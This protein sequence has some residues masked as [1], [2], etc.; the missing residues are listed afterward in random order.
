MRPSRTLVALI[1]VTALLGLLVGVPRPAPAEAATTPFTDI[2]GSPFKAD[3]E[4]L[5]AEGITSGCTATLY[6][7]DGKVTRGQMAA[8]LARMFNP[9]ATTTDYFTDDETSIFE[10]AINRLRAAGIAS[11]CAA[12]KFCPEALVARDQMTSFLSRAIPLS[13]GVGRN[14]FN[15]D[16]GNLHEANIDRAAMAGIASGCATWQFCPAG[17]VTRGQM[18]AF[19]HRVTQPVAPPPYP[20]PAPTAKP[21]PTPTPAPLLDHGFRMDWAP[22]VEALCGGAVTVDDHQWRCPYA[23][24]ELI[25]F[26]YQRSELCDTCI[27][28]YGLVYFQDQGAAPVGTGPVPALQKIADTALVPSSATEAKAW[29]AGAIPQSTAERIAKLLSDI[30]ARALFEIYPGM[31]EFGL[32]QPPQRL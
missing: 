29:I 8:F 25:W 2:A 30:R 22:R 11:G 23:G 24:G 12:T 28:P 15:D 16:N 1:G 3:I 7:P 13:L 19:L 31:W 4:W 9:P 26:V 6:C 5:Y 18:A 20:A 32:E 21:T 14:Y 17:N 27:W 10:S